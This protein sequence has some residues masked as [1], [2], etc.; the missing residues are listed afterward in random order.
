[1]GVHRG[2]FLR[3][4]GDCDWDV[5]R[6]GCVVSGLAPCV[7]TPTQHEWAIKAVGQSGKGWTRWNLQAFHEADVGTQLPVDVVMQHPAEASNHRPDQTVPCTRKDIR[8]L[9]ARLRSVVVEEDWVFR[10]NVTAGFG[11]VTEDFGPS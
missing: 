5:P 6:G 2:L 11:I 9:G 10:T 3:P 4:Q 1:M 7:L 8:G